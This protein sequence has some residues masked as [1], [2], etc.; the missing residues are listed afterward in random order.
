MEENSRQICSSACK[1]WC[2][3]T[4]VWPLVGRRT[5]APMLAGDPDT[6]NIQSKLTAHFPYHTQPQAASFSLR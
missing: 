2:F 6:E 3:V 5:A 1:E 4:E